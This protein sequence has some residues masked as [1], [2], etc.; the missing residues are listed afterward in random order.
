MNARFA[1]IEQ[2][3]AARSDE[4]R[5]EASRRVA[6]LMSA[7]PAWVMVW[8]AF[9]CHLIA[10]T[11][12]ARD[13]W[14]HLTRIDDDATFRDGSAFTLPQ[15]SYDLPPRCEEPT[16]E[17]VP[18]WLATATHSMAFLLETARE[19]WASVE[20][21]DEIMLARGEERIQAETVWGQMEPVLEWLIYRRRQYTHADDPFP[22]VAMLAMADETDDASGGARGY[23]RFNALLESSRLPRNAYAEARQEMLAEA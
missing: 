19:S 14:L 22:A 20:G 11:L 4:E 9:S 3:V 5:A 17:A 13:P 18:G 2:Y 16:H 23:N 6:A 15:A 1:V 10:H 7:D 21:L 8:W 12:P